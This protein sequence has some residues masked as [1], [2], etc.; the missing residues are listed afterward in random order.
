MGCRSK[1]PRQPC[2]PLP[3]LASR[4]GDAEQG[5]SGLVADLPMQVFKDLPTFWDP[6]LGVLRREGRASSPVA[7]F[8]SGQWEC[9]EKPGRGPASIT[10]SGGH[11]C[12]PMGEPGSTGAL[13]AWERAGGQSCGSLTPSQP[14]SG[15]TPTAS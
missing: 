7:H 2:P 9:R 14:S 11:L 8:R 12:V 1:Q 6:Y 13:Q 3:L 4:E 15:L 10:P 5:D